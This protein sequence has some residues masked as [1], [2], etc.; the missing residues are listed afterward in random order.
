VIPIL[1]SE[2][3]FAQFRIPDSR[4]KI[5]FTEEKNTFIVITYEGNYYKASFDLEKGGECVKV[6]EKK[7]INN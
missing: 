1:K 5:A 3:S 7:I 6:D 2:W 4:I